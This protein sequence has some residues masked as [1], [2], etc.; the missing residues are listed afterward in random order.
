MSDRNFRNASFGKRIA[1]RLRNFL[2]VQYRK[3]ICDMGGIGMKKEDC[4]KI[5]LSIAG[6]E[7]TVYPGL[8]S[9]RPIIY[10]NTFEGEGGQVF[11][12]LRDMGC[13]DFTLVTVSGLDWHRDMT[14][15]EMPPVSEGAPPCKGGADE[16][17]RIVTEEIVPKAEEAM[18]G[19]VSWRGLAGYSLAGLFALY[20]PYRTALFSRIAS[21]SGSLW[22]PG[23][24]EY[25]ST[26]ETDGHVSHLYLSLGD[27]ECRTGNPYMKTVQERT[28]KIADLY[29]REGIDTT[30]QLNPGSHFKNTLRRTAAGIAWL[31]D[32]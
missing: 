11:R 4:Q 32:R 5:P 16:Y 30:F 7:I 9:C 17:L 12:L 22:F 24:W 31:L 13:P 21:M 26:H 10:L 1:S 2:L 14:P 3:Q 15:W 28:E 8:T 18:Q 23:F 25:V 6:R 27:R 29:A 20:A 19:P